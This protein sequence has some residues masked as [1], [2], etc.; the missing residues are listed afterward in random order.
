MWKAFEHWTGR[1][2]EGFTGKAGLGWEQADIHYSWPDSVGLS[3]DHLQ[4]ANFL[5]VC[6]L[7]I[8]LFEHEFP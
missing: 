1:Y 3:Y 6:N 5:T 4:R 2:S 8:N 7:P